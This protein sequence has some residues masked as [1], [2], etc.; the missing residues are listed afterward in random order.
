MGNVHKYSE[1]YRTTWGGFSS[2]L[3]GE[4]S[5]KLTSA[6]FVGAENYDVVIEQA[7]YS[8]IAS[9]SVVT[10]TLYQASTTAG[11]GSKTVTSASTSVT[12]TAT[13]DTGVLTVQVRGAELDMGSGFKYVGAIASTN[14]ASGTE[15]VQLWHVQGRARY[16]QAVLP[17]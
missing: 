9:G 14:N 11:A 8:G 17:S 10:L 5:D 12:S 6:A 16:P 3:G 7:A 15:Q 13:T 1:H 4:T 2:A